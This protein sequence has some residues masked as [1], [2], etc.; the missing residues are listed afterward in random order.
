MD[1]G[2][3]VVPPAAVQRGPRG[4]YVYVVGPEATVTRQAIT[5]GY[6]DEQLSVVT[7][8]LKGGERIVVDGASRLSDGSKVVVTQPAAANETP[9]TDQPSAP[10][11][12]RRR[13][14]GAGQGGS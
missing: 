2:A 14:G 4:A 3:V 1:R 6:E 11:A 8:G 7:E 10:G 12:R 9:A 5:V 13:A